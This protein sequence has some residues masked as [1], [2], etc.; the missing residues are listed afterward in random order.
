MTA[1]NDRSRYCTG[2]VTAFDIK[3]PQHF[4]YST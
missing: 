2:K 3:C 4:G 1:W